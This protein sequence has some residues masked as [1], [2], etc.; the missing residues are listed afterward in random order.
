MNKINS[1]LLGLSLAATSVTLAAAQQESPS[2]HPKVLQI[3]REWIKPYKNGAAH[4][5][6]E[7]AFITAMTRA[8][9]PVHY[10]ALNSMSGRSRALYL[11]R[12]DSFADWESANKTVDKNA[13]LNAELEHAGIADGEL[14]DQVDSEVFT[15]DEELSYKTRPDLSHARYLEI[16]VFHVRPGHRKE[17]HEVVK[18]VKDANDKGGTSAHWGLYDIAYGG[19]DGTYIA[20]SSDGSMA[21]IDKGFAENKKFVDGLGGEEGLKKLDELFG[22]AVE[23]SRSELFSINPKQ[24]Y[25]DEAWIKADPGFWKPKAPEAAV[26]KPAAKPASPATA[27]PA[28]R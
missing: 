19:D 15:F 16:T 2:A 21:D 26:T 14:L 11:T 28:S 5:K 1:I 18:M 4:D 3:T 10:I 25:V 17:W 9:F 20:L 23:S 22:S 27:K 6:T 24:S 8:N 12:Y 7:S 13:G